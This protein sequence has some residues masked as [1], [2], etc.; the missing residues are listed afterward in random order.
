MA[1]S[2]NRRVV[3]TGIG[4][5]SSVGIGTDATWNALLRGE[6][7]IGTIQQ[8]DATEF[9]CRVA[10]EVKGFDPANY[11]EKKEIKKMGRFIQLAIAAAD[12]AIQESG[13]KVSAEDAELTGV[14][15]GSGIGGWITGGFTN[16][17][18]SSV[19]KLFVGFGTSD[20]IACGPG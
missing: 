2:S 1:A 16:A 7:G 9:N 17:G 20:T 6:S 3:V 13:L 5:L 10:G 4:L 8:F 12:F 19:W 11:I 15:I 14:Y 18:C